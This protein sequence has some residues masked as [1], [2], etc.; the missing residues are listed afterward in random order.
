MRHLMASTRSV[1]VASS[2]CSVFRGAQRTVFSASSVLSP[3]TSSHFFSAQEDARNATRLRAGNRNGNKEGEVY[4]NSAVRR[5]L[6]STTSTRGFAAKSS[7]E[8]EEEKE[9]EEEEETTTTSTLKREE[10]EEETTTDFAKIDGDSVG[11][12]VKVNKSELPLDQCKAIER[13]FAFTG[14]NCLLY[15]KCDEALREVVARHER[16]HL[17]GYRGSGKSVSLAILVLRERALGSLVVYL[18]RT[19]YMVTRTSY[20]KH[21]EGEDLWDTPDAARVFLHAVAAKPNEALLGKMKASDGKQTLLEVVKSGLEKADQYVTQN[22]IDVVDELVKQKD[23]RVIF[24]FDEHNALYGPSD[25]HEVKGPRSRKNIHSDRLRLALKLRS[26]FPTANGGRYVAC[27]STTDVG[28][29]NPVFKSEDENVFDFEIPK[30]SVAETYAVLK[31]Y[32]EVG[33]CSRG[34]NKEVAREFKALTNGKVKEIQEYL[35]FQSI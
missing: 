15:R 33:K 14:T 5:R 2:S 22:A 25:M 23:F 1:A 13:E 34:I 8:E 20:Q 6:K 19:S 28:S 26:C 11:K 9:E 29:S 31:H 4:Y 12:Y 27:E 16:V 24:A 35:M 21:G 30:F 17:R 18:P 3:S 7:G 32:E 10:R